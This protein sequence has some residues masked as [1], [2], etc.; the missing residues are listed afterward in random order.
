MRRAVQQPQRKGSAADHPAA[1]LSSRGVAAMVAFGCMAPAMVA[2][3]DWSLGVSAWNVAAVA[4]IAAA[5]LFVQA[6]FCATSRA[7]SALFG[8]V[9]ALL[10]V[11]NIALAFTS[12]SHATNDARDHRSATIAEANRQS[13]QRSQWSQA[14]AAAVAIAGERPSGT[15]RSE[16]DALTSANARRWATTDN[17]APAAI[18]ASL[19]IAF[20]ERLNMLRGQF[21]AAQRRDHLDTRIAQLDLEAAKVVAPAATDP[22]SDSLRLLAATLGVNLSPK[23]AAALPA[24]RDFLRAVAIEL[25]AALGP[26]AWLGLVGVS[27]SSAVEKPKR[28]IARRAALTAPATSPFAAFAD[29]RLQVQ[30]GASLRAGDTWDGFQRWCRAKGLDPGSQRA[31]GQEMGRRFKRDRNNGRPQ[32]LGISW[33]AAPSGNVRRL[34]LA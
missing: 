7:I 5:A 4:S 23:T 33:K 13:S 10:T 14:R 18:T 1:F 19:S 6:A 22:F 3:V 28:S 15:I 31:F 34:R 26:A 9:A 17:C 11:V 27:G 20:C 21:A 2:N 25:I 16:I 30:A 8:G 32:Y 24:L 29:E 12:V